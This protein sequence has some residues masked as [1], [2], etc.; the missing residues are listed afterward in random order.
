MAENVGRRGDSWFF[1]IDLPP[2]PDGQRRQRR[3]GGFATDREAR[4]AL[5]PTKGDI[6]S[7][8]FRP[9]ARRTVGDL[10]AEW[11]ETVRPCRKASTFSNYGWLMT[12]MPPASNRRT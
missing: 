4:R 9:G 1:R 11:L 8:R 12:R 3:A 2:G 7:G 5:G 6:D 10:A